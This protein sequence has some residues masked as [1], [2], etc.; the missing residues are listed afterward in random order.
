MNKVKKM[1]M[2]NLRGELTYTKNQK[3]FSLSKNKMV[4]AIATSMKAQDHDSITQ[5]NNFI[6]P[7]LI[8]SLVSTVSPLSKLTRDVCS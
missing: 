6:T 2:K 7:V 3:T 5:I 1:F 4:Q 8:N